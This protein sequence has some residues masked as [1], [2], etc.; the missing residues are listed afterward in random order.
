VARILIVDDS[1][2]NRE[3]LHAYLEGS[4]HEL[5]DAASGEQ[6]L[7]LAE[8]TPPDLVLL[9]V[10]MPG[11]D[12]FE[13]ARRL[14]QLHATNFLPVILVTSLAD[15]ASRVL[16]L[17]AGADEFLSKPV[18]AQELHVRIRSLLALRAKDI[19]LA[20][21]NLALTELDRF[22]TEMSSLLVHDL[23]GLVAVVVANHDFLADRLRDGEPMVLESIEDSRS[24]AQR[25]L[26]LLVNLL[27][28]TRME[29][30]RIELVRSSV[31]V[32]GLLEGLVKQHRLAARARKLTV[33]MRV[34]NGLRVLADADMLSR[35]VAN[36]VENAM[37]YT[38]KAGCILLSADVADGL[39]RIRIGNTGSAIPRAARSVIFEKFA[40]VSPD[41]GRMNLGLGLYFC[42]LALEAHGGRIWVDETPE[43]ATVFVLELP[44]EAA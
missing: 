39:A 34:E 42:R 12:G 19:A 14:K 9:D 41:H 37:R 8:A 22:K 40:Q 43:L 28:T 10:M 36:I 31:D 29:A 30:N 20:A 7:A 15:Q 16:G 27:D 32:H 21:Q 2:V 35:V 17:D 33:D 13:T 23:R 1:K 24:A 4:G 44:A 6:A 38:P 26:N 5:V 25:L 11:I 3:L 18:D